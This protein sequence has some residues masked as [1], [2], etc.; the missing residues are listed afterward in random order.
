MHAFILRTADDPLT[1]DGYKIRA[2]QQ[3]LPA[4]LD[5]VQSQSWARK[6]FGT[7][8]SSKEPYVHVF[9]MRNKLDLTFRIG[10]EHKGDEQSPPAAGGWCVL[11][12]YDTPECYGNPLTYLN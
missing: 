1:G 5:W 2:P 9:C 4:Q 11:C 8:F 7:T 6:Q 10:V 12:A 3:F